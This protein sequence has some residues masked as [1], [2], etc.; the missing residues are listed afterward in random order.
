[1]AT[2]PDPKQASFPRREGRGKGTNIIGGAYV[3]PKEVLALIREKEVKAIDLRFMDF[4]GMWQHF[5][6]PADALDEGVFDEGL[7]FDGSSIRGWQAINESDMLVI[8]VPE[9]AFIDP[10]CKDTTRTTTCNSQDALSWED[11]TADPRKIARKAVNYM[12][13]TGI[14]DTAYFGPEL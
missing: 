8:P 12:K 5:S 2:S 4:P 11:Y 10:F 1:M 9:T 7:G 6:I 14:A 13:S 3:T